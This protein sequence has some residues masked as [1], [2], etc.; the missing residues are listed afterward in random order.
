LSADKPGA[1]PCRSPNCPPNG[2]SRPSGAGFD[3]GCYELQQNAAAVLQ[4][5]SASYSVSESAIHAVI[6]VLRTGDTSG[7]VTVNYATSDGTATADR[8]YLAASGP[9]TF[10]PGQTSQTFQVTILLD[11]VP[12]GSETVNLTLSSPTGGAGLGKQASAV[13]VINDLLPLAGVAVPSASRS[14]P[15]PGL[16]PLAVDA[17]MA[18]VPSP[19]AG[20]WT[21]RQPVG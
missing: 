6:T 5:S 9:L 8:D 12:D 4:F 20:A 2:N 10:A 18:G 21:H 14:T 7:T 13:L 3:I 19:L 16:D 1:R 15:A 11:P 17:L